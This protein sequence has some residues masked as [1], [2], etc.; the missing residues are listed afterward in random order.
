[1]IL[2][3]LL[4]WAI[5]SGQTSIFFI[6]TACLSVMIT[7]LIDK[8]LFTISP[9]FLGFNWRWFVFAGHLL[10]AM[11]ISTYMVLKIIWLSPK[12]V[13]PIYGLIPAQSK[14]TNT[15]VTQTNCI[16]LTPGTMSMNIE[17]DTILVHAMSEEAIQ[18][19]YVIPE[20]KI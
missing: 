7:I 13:K 6:I 10:K 5:L 15:Q 19:L 4:F 1:M 2:F 20:D 9:I 3:L 14:N 17:N 16:T 18:D 12:G 11:L 8:K